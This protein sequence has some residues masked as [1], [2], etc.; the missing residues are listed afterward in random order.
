VKFSVVVATYDRP[1]LLAQTLESLAGQS[2]AQRDFEV[3]VVDGTPGVRP[4]PHRDGLTYLP[5]AFANTSA[6]RNLGVEKSRGEIVAFID[7]DAEADPHWLQALL[8]AHESSPEVIGVGGR[9]EVVWPGARPRWLPP[10]L[11]SYYSRRDLGDAR[12]SFDPPDGP[13]GANMSVRRETLEALGGF[14][15]RLSPKG[16]GLVA[17]EE[18]EFFQ[19]LYEKG[20]RVIYEP[21]AL[22][23]HHCLPNRF[24]R[25]WVMRRAWGQGATYAIT[26]DMRSPGTRRIHSGRSAIG[27]ARA[28]FRSKRALLLDLL[29]PG[30]RAQ[31][32]TRG[33][34]DMALWYGYAFE[35]LRMALGRR[36]GEAEL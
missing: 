22:V 10:E 34:V 6:A 29:R 2:L 13:Y 19:R 15:T 9:I 35:N 18:I 11:D 7:D 28:T 17:G 4:T 32:L 24:T 27:F 33:A 3:V 26:D 14:S 1:T 16:K 8:E 5:V 30:A 25:R 36:T 20:G 31:G 21:R 23:R 12:K